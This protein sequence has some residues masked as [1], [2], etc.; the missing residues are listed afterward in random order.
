MVC[1][2]TD[3]LV[4]FLRNDKDALK[5]IEELNEK[6]EAF[7][8]S[9]VVVCELYK[10]A[11]RSTKENYINFIET[12]IDGLIILEINRMT[13]RLYGEHKEKLKHAPIG[14]F[15]LLIAC[16]ALAHNERVITRN[17]REFEKVEDLKVEKW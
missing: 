14:D 6:N 17:L 4:G 8:V 2:D 16:T 13:C 9:P 1:L 15:D 12:H 7:A 10:G 5:K 3:I 11:F